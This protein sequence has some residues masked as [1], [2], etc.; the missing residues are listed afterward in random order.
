LEKGQHFREANF[1]WQVLWPDFAE[2]SVF[3]KIIGIA[4]RAREE[5]DSLVQSLPNE[6]KDV[7]ESVS[8]ALFRELTQREGPDMPIRGIEL[9]PR[10]EGLSSESRKRLGMLENIFHTVADTLTLIFTADIIAFFGDADRQVLDVIEP[11]ERVPLV[12]KSP[13]HGTRFGECLQHI[14]P[15]LLM[16]SRGSSTGR[17]HPSYLN[18]ICPRLI[19]RTD[20]HGT[21]QCALQ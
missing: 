1:E 5:I 9:L 3:K 7:Y 12:I 18:S 21:C 2:L 10:W 15:I 13:H 19:L 17:L 8:S 14:D 11:P 4:E 16:I 20:I 6:Q